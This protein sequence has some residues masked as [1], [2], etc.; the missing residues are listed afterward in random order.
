MGPQNPQENGI[1][2]DP[3]LNA[4]RQLRFVNLEEPG[5]KVMAGIVGGG[6]VFQT[7][8]KEFALPPD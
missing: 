4:T 1:E 3:G 6:C 8:V 7:A 5:F 2:G